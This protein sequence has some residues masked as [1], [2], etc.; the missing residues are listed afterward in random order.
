MLRK[1]KV[2]ALDQLLLERFGGKV[3]RGLALELSRRRNPLSAW[4]PLFFKV[5]TKCQPRRPSSKIG[6]FGHLGNNP[7]WI[8][9]LSKKGYGHGEVLARFSCQNAD[10]DHAGCVRCGYPHLLSKVHTAL[11]PKRANGLHKIGAP[12]AYLCL[13][14]FDK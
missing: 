11:T 4:T 1:A 9:G 6:H 8:D 10:L 13:N 12:G 7:E 14:G 2:C 5:S 3:G